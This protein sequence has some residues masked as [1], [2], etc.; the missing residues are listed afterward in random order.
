[1]NIMIINKAPNSQSFHPFTDVSP[2]W[3]TLI[4]NVP[5]ML[6]YSTHFILKPFSFGAINT[7]TTDNE[8]LFTMNMEEDI[9]NVTMVSNYRIDT[10]S[11]IH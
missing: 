11:N 8:S 5:T 4:M 10:R 2:S 9:S 6:F 1:M 7:F 3:D